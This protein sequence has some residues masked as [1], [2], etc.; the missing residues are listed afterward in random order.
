MTAEQIAGIF[1]SV[2]TLERALKGG[3]CLWRLSRG[4]RH[5]V[6]A[7]RVSTLIVFGR[8]QEIEVKN[9]GSL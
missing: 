2:L 8:L 3:F 5:F 7:V 1:D 4:V 6:E 9:V